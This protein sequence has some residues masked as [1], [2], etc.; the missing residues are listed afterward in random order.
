MAAIHNSVSTKFFSNR[1]FLTLHIPKEL[2]AMN[3]IKIF[4][5]F[6]QWILFIFNINIEKVSAYRESLILIFLI[7]L[8][9]LLEFN[10]C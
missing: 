4:V 3:P 1:I 6:L 5:N 2:R 7:F 10:L 9:F 8:A